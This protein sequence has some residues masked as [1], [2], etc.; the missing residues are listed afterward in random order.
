MEKRKASVRVWVFFVGNANVTS[1]KDNT[2]LE[3]AF[4]VLNFV[5]YLKQ[6]CG[7]VR[8][9]QIHTGG[10]TESRTNHPTTELPSPPSRLVQPPPH[11]LAGIC[12]ACTHH[13][14]GFTNHFNRVHSVMAKESIPR[15]PL[16]IQLVEAITGAVGQG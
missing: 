4:F 11:F 6:A 12:G 5:L 10:I 9:P 3:M 15:P 2:G 1:A 16:W 8:K 13:K 7:V 14:G